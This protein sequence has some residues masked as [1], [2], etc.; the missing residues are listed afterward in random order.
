MDIQAMVGGAVAVLMIPSA[1]W[2]LGKFGPAFVAKKLHEG[3]EAAKSTDWVRAK[4]SRAKWLL[5]T[6]QLLEEEVPEPGEGQ[7]IYDAAG[8]WIAERVKIGSA[9]QWAKAAR[10][11]GDAVDTEL[12]EDIKALGADVPPAP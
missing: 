2:A 10:Q 7:A 12:D 9:E 4:P 3:F 6:A 5:V 8:A 11:F 1:F